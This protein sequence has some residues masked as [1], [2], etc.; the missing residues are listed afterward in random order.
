TYLLVARSL[1]VNPRFSGKPPMTMNDFIKLCKHSPP[2]KSAPATP[3]ASSPKPIRAMSSKLARDCAAE[4]AYLEGSKLAALTQRRRALHDLLLFSGL[5]L[6]AMTIVSAGAGWVVAGRVLR[7]VRVIT[8]TARRA[9]EQHLGERIAL[10]GARD[11]LKEL[12]D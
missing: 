3:G 9:S 2:A 5:G 6:G 8:G 11:E 12:A 10:S 1:P 4:A 7:P